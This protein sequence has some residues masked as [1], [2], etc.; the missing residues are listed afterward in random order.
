MHA[1]MSNVYKKVYIWYMFFHKDEITQ[2][3]IGVRI[4]DEE[5]SNRK[6]SQSPLV[7]LAAEA[8]GFTVCEDEHWDWHG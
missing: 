4:D 8:S 2:T 3:W 1:E 5:P 7:L 6:G